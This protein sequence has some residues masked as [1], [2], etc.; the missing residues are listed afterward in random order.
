MKKFYFSAL[1]CIIISLPAF[2]QDCDP[3]GDPFCDG[4]TDIPLDSGIGILIALG[5]IYGI[6][7]KQENPKIRTD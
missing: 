6:K 3:L 4:D 5:A 7:K 2:S 1:F